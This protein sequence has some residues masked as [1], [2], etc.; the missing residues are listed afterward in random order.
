MLCSW[1]VIDV[2]TLPLW[3]ILFK[4]LPNPWCWISGCK[5]HRA[6]RTSYMPRLISFL[7]TIT[8]ALPRIFLSPF[9]FISLLFYTIRITLSK[10][11]CW[12]VGCCVV[13]IC[14]FL[15]VDTAVFAVTWQRANR[16]DHGSQGICPCLWQSVPI[17]TSFWEL[18]FDMLVV[19]VGLIAW[20]CWLLM[21]GMAFLG[22]LAASVLLWSSYSGY[23]LISSTIST[24]WNIFLRAFFWYVN[25]CGGLD[26]LHLLA[27]DG[28]HHRFWSF[29]SELTIMIVTAAA[30]TAAAQQELWW[31]RKSSRDNRWLAIPSPSDLRHRKHH[32]Y[33]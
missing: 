25:C 23:S 4:C 16:Y 22:H 21:V 29:G 3:C 18:S 10:A 24:D 8:S 13:W 30:G 31:F 15:T 17:E 27:C 1:I 5:F 11:F 9:A 7:S 12:C 32:I 2:W 28:W 14:W 20:I 33:H 19:A 6:A 26:R